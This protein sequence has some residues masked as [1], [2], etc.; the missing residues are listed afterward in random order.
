MPICVSPQ[1]FDGKRSA[2]VFDS[3]GTPSRWNIIFGRA[4]VLLLRHWR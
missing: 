4:L 3:S 2:N 1:F